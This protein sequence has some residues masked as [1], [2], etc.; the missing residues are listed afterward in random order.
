MVYAPGHCVV[1]LPTSERLGLIS[2]N[3]DAVSGS[4]QPSRKNV[5]HD[6]ADLNSDWSRCFTKTYG[7]FGETALHPKEDTAPLIDAP[8]RNSIHLLLQIKEKLKSIATE[9]VISMA[10]AV[11]K[12]GSL[13]VCIN[14]QKL[15]KSLKHNPHKVPTLEINPGWWMQKSFQSS[16]LN[17]GTSL[18]H[19]ANA[20]NS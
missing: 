12:D 20:V 11:E 10:Y 14:P 15:N 4:E 16:M 19:S 3:V 7:E 13:R 5:I 9:G 2:F 1:G 17:P 8:Q 6:K 18:S